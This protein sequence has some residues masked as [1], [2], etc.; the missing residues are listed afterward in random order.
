MRKTFLFVALAAVAAYLSAA[1]RT[2]EQMRAIAAAKL[3]PSAE[4]KG[5]QATTEPAL[6]LTCVSDQPAYA[7]F[8]RP[9]A[10][11]FAIVAK[12]DLVDPVIGYSATGR[13]APDDMPLPLQWFLREMSREIEAAEQ[14]LSHRAPRRA[15][16]T[17]T[18]VENFVTT[19]WSQEYPFDRKTPN[20]YPSGCV[21]TA[22]AQCM[23]YCQWPASASFEGNYYVTTKKGNKDNTES[24]TE[25]VSSTYTWP[26]SDT[27]KSFGR[28]T[29]NIDELMRDCGYATYMNYA[30]S[31]SG[32]VSYLAGIALTNIFSYPQQSVKYLDYEYSS[33]PD[34]W[35]QIIY[36]E[37]ALR[38]PVY[39]SASDATMGGHAF[40]LSGVD[41]EGLVYVN[42]GWRGTADG[43]Y[44]I[45]NLN[46]TQGGAEYHFDSSMDIIYGIRSAALPTDHV[47]GRI[48]GFS[49][50][51]FTFRFTTETDDDGVDHHTLFCDLPYGFVNYNAS[52]FCGVFGLF[53]RDLTD[54][55]DWV[56]APDLQDRDTIPAGYGYAGTSAQY[57][58]FAFYYYIDGDQGLKP[59][60]TYHLSFG[61]RDDRD[62][63]WH[64]ILCRGGE[65]GYE[66]TYTGDPET[67]TV[68]ATSREVPVLT[69]INGLRPDAPTANGL[70]ADDSL[71]RVF[72]ASGRLVYT[73]PTSS[74]NLWDIPARG[75]LVIK[76]GTHARKIVR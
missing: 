51:P 22:L 71:T 16:A 18:P 23:N 60:H 13:Y 55:T 3:S 41:D 15:Q 6:K 24:H 28:Y 72:D 9:E 26:Y 66:V 40:L 54:G 21:A 5:R 30:Q 29:D 74:F 19:Q 43:F 14:G 44:A 63:Q 67:S 31:G 20:N 53:G 42:W 35:A 12:S 10:P 47:E 56:I 57:K 39:Y 36:D 64:S 8:A 62:N 25:Q 70:T 68:V 45:T 17:F 59:G 58:D 2:S 52:D 61:V 69:A 37:L 1:E 34:A 38:S 76:Q 11:G 27:Y 75:L 7:V 73:A 4:V 46:P 50:D 65:L 33:G 32:T 48:F 49:G